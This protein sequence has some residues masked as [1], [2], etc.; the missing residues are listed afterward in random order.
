MSEWISEWISVR[1]R[2]PEDQVE[3]LVATRSKNGVRNIDKG[4]LAID[5][6]IHRGCAE[7]THWMPLP[8]PPKEDAGKLAERRKDGGK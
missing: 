4:Y 3:V 2:L 7:V 8:E 6:F 1:D 5:H